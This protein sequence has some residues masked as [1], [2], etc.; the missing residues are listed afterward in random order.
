MEAIKDY[1]YGRKEIIF[2]YLYGSLARETQN[3]LSDIDLA[4][5]IDKD[6]KPKSG[7]FGYRSEIIAELGPLVE[8]E[9]DLIV[10]NDVSLFL[11]FN[12]LKEG[13]L[14]FSKSEEKKVRFH[15][16]TMKRYLDFLPALAVQ[17][18]YLKKRLAEGN[19]GR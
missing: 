8:R 10:L 19:F 6:K 3:K 16:S 17:E 18:R 14:L 2:A 13:T 12:V 15:D 4:V 1:L 11:A 9:V 5:Y 7:P